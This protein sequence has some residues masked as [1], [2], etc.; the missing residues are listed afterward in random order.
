MYMFYIINYGELLTMSDESIWVSMR[1]WFGF[2]WRQC[3]E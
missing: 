3:K 1:P 2:E